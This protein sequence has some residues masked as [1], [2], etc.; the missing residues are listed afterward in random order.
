MFLCCP[1]HFSTTHSTQ[2]P[3]TNCTT[4][5]EHQ[6][7][8][9]DP[10]SVKTI[11]SNTQSNQSAGAASTAAESRPGPR[12]CISHSHAAKSA[13]CLATLKETWQPFAPFPL[14]DF[15]RY[16]DAGRRL[17]IPKQSI[18]L[19]MQPWSNKCM[20][21]PLSPRTSP[22]IFWSKYLQQRDCNGWGLLLASVTPPKH[23]H[24]ISPSSRQARMALRRA[25]SHHHPSTPSCSMFPLGTSV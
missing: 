20:T 12:R 17:G 7:L 15:F 4:K 11:C 23:F 25:L 13:I 2:S 6:A 9:R 22:T 24:C 18:D 1:N 19:R 10:K 14:S 21:C 16:F 5:R 8:I 3:H